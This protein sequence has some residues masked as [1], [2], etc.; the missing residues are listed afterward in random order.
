VVVSATFNV[1]FCF[2]VVFKFFGRLVSS[3]FRPGEFFC[4][5]VCWLSELQ[6]VEETSPGR[7]EDG[8]SS[9]HVGR[10]LE[11]IIVVDVDC[12]LSEVVKVLLTGSDPVRLNRPSLLSLVTTEPIDNLVGQPVVALLKIELELSLVAGECC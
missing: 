1:G 2:S 8:T 11:L 10:C 7:D 5:K 3:E 4:R 12:L 9:E 6:V